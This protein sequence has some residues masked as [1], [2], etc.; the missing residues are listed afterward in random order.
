[1]EPP[2]ASL[3]TPLARAVFAIGPRGR[4]LSPAQAQTLPL[5]ELAIGD[6]TL[7][8]TDAIV[9]PV[10]GGQV[11][12]AV[13]RT[14]GP[15]LDAALRERIAELV[16]PRLAAGQIVVTSGFGLRTKHVLHCAPPVYADDPVR[17]RDELEA[18][19]VEVLRVAQRLELISLSI[20]AIATGARRFPL[21]E[22][23]VIATRVVIEGIRGQT[24]LRLV[25]FVLNGP[26]TLE[27]YADAARRQLALR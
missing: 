13:R 24:A 16:P 21:P 4:K 1:V 20:P 7:E 26:A 8:A 18:C 2:A 17:A 27:V 9:N 5:L 6:V 3:R 19:H 22:A 23:A 15:A 11:D 10:G 25:R 12:Q 14:A